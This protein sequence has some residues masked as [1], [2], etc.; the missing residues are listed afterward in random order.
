MKYLVIGGVAAGTKTAAKLK[1]MNP[2]AEVT[3]LTK[4]K[5]ISYA[6]CGLPYYISGVIPNKEQL[7]VNTPAK[8][9]A[10]TGAKVLTEREAICLDSENKQVTAKNLRTGLEESYSYD[11]CIIACGASAIVPP[12]P[13]ISLPGVFT[14]RTPEDAIELKEYLVQNDVK[15]AVVVGGGFIG[16]E[17]AENL[18]AQG[19]AV[20]VVDMA[21]QIMPGFDMELADYA[22]RHLEK[23]GINVLLKTKVDSV[24]G[25]W[26][27]EGI[28]VA[29]RQIKADVV[30]LSLGIRPNTAFLKG[31]GIELL[32]NGTIAV[33]HQMKTNLPH[34]YAAGDCVSVT[35]RITGEREWSPMGSS[36]NMEGRTLAETL[37]GKQSSYPGVLGTAVLKL[38]ELNCG[39]TGLSEKSAREKGFDVVSVIVAL[40]DK[41]HYYPGASTFIIKVIAD[42]KTDKLLGLQ[43]LGSGTVDKVVDS[44]VVALTMGATV[45]QLQNM[46]MAYAPPFSTAIHPFVT[47]INVLINKLEGR[48]D[49]MT[50]AEF[51]QGKAE[52][53]RMIDSARTPSISNAP[54]V[55]PSEVNGEIPGIRKEEKLLLICNRGKR[56]YLLQNRLRACGYTN[57]KVLEGGLAVNKMPTNTGTVTVSAEDI[58][59][60]KAWGFLH[61]KGTDCFNARIITRNGK[62][63]AEENQAITEAAQ[64]FGNGEI[65]MT[66]RLT[67][68]IQG[69]PYNNIEPLRSFMAEHNMETGGTGSKVRPVVSCKGTTCQY[70]LIDTFDL[71]N[72]IHE[73]FFKGYN[74]V[75][76]PHKFKIAVGGCPNNCV[77]PNLNDLGIVG[78][79]VPDFQ[80]E[81]CRGCK[82]CQVEKTCP[83]KAAKLVDGVLKIDDDICNNCGRCIQSCPFKAMPDGQYG[84]RVYIGGRWGKKFAHGRPLETV[85]TSE[86]QVL[87]IVEKAILLFREQGETGER[88][89]DTIERLGFEN[90]Q[91]QLL[92]N[93]L[94]ERKDEIVGASLHLVGGATC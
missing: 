12:I 37:G 91:Q 60:V 76:L 14:M 70:G 7:I 49:S 2:N 67:V 10:L 9:T 21:D 18:A 71:S 58:K 36:A 53:Y 59:R 88:F 20:T 75:K 46:D 23:K 39:R 44:A 54:Y 66:S 8:F 38:P 92:S 29:D 30:V 27:A 90:V 17:A 79:R 77:K 6:G 57:T 11:E 13:G 93:D 83:V 32:P 63:T 28:Q 85:F 78:Q 3:I 40:D 81:L 69:V 16:L 45:Y 33:D 31:T 22:K 82:V 15:R 24:L 41:A 50:P 64:K 86:E 94:L 72:K 89:S 61:N 4:S 65:A 5:D 84:Y 56:A 73:R 34:V 19:I 80:E 74:D 25:E 87:Q 35:N 26:K 62:I 52:G 47:A 42:K 43:V 1:R 68:E 48:M 51:M 55:E